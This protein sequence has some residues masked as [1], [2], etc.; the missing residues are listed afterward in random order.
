MPSI[1]IVVMVVLGG[2]GSVSGAAIAAILLIAIPEQLHSIDQYRMVIY[3]L[4][5]ITLMLVRPKG[6]FGSEELD[7]HWLKGQG[8]AIK[9]LI[10]GKNDPLKNVLIG[11][12][13]CVLGVTITAFSYNKFQ[14]NGLYIFLAWLPAI[15]GTISLL[16][17]MAAA[18]QANAK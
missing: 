18:N 6:I 16:R 5:L 4:L 3:S 11:T 14:L 7:K 10:Q 13:W 15:L 2:M 12:L 9:L 1:N 8:D 17:G